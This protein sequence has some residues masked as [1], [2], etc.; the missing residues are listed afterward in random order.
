MCGRARSAMAPRDVAAAAG[1]P[2]ERWVDR[3]RYRPGANL[4]PGAY[5]PVLR[6]S[7]GPDHHLELQSMK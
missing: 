7:D 1:V 2:P 5:L 4:S 3:D 6:R